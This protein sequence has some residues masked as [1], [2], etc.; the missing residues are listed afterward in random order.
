MTRK[1]VQ[2]FRKLEQCF[3][4]KDIGRRA[5][6][7]KG[8]DCVQAV[9]LKFEVIHES[10]AFEPEGGTLAAA[11]AEGGKRAASAGFAEL[12]QGC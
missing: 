8:Q 7:I 12:V 2:L 5:L 3:P 10:G 11:D 1:F 9:G 6:A 4:I